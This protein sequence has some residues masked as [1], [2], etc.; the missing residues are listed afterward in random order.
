MKDERG[1]NA[2]AAFHAAIDETLG[3]RPPSIPINAPKKNAAPHSRVT[4]KGCCSPQNAVKLPYA[5]Q[6]RKG[7]LL[8]LRY[9]FAMPCSPRGGLFASLGRG[10]F[11]LAERHGGLKL[12]ALQSCLP[13]RRIRS[14]T[15]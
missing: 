4:V 11:D 7:K 8:S 1:G 5:S 14:S 3:F 9:T 15:G 6:A 2:C 12:A 10:Y 13:R